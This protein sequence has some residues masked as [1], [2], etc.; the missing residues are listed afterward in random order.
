MADPQAQTAAPPV[1]FI[2]AIVD[3][4]RRRRQTPRPRRDAVSARAER[5][6][7]HRPREVDLPQFRRRRRARRHLQPALRRHQSRPRRTSSTSTPSRK[8]SRGSA[9]RGT[10][11]LFASDYFERLYEFAV[12]LIRRDRRM[13][14]ASPRRRFAAVSRHADRAGPQQPVPRSADRREPRSVRADAGRRVRGRRARAAR[15]DR[16]GVAQPEHARS[17]A[18]PHPPRDASPDGRCL[19]HLPDVRLRASAV[20][21]ARRHHALAVHAGVRGPSA[22]LRLAGQQPGLCR[23]PT[24][25]RSRSSSRG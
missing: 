13:S 9:S 17:D 8:T 21:C 15:E 4:D 11:L 24:T 16:H 3:E 20:R 25:G 22:A 5:L 7:A 1:D 10:E 19:V 12:Q 14:T 23:S 2:R 6:P 18:L